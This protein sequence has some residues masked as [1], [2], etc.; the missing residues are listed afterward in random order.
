MKAILPSKAL[1][2]AR[3]IWDDT[4]T[5]VSQGRAGMSDDFLKQFFIHSKE[6]GQEIMDLNKDSLGDRFNPMNIITHRRCLNRAI[7]L[8]VRVREHLMMQK[9][10]VNVQINGSFEPEV[11]TRRYR[12]TRISQD[13]EVHVYWSNTPL[14]GDE[15]NPTFPS[16]PAATSTAAGTVAVEVET[17]DLPLYEESTTVGLTLGPAEWE[18][19][20]PGLVRALLDSMPHGTAGGKQITVGRRDE[21]GML[22]VQFPNAERVLAFENRWNAQPPPGYEDVPALLQ[23]V[24]APDY[25]AAPAYE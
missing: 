9:I 5:I 4:F 11:K 14:H 23:V 24:P 22:V 17:A 2:Q 10:Q 6:A 13:R 19:N 18:D 15:E 21:C 20:G 16:A 25:S 12:Q 1:A 7:E 8:R 3:Q